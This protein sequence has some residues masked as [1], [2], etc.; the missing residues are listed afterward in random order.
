MSKF[1][2]LLELLLENCQFDS[3]N[4]SLGFVNFTSLRVLALSKNHFNYEIPNWFSNLST[5]LLQLY[6]DNSFL[7][8]NIPPCIFSLEK[9]EYLSLYTNKLTEQIPEPLVQLKHLTYLDLGLNSLNG[10]TPSFIGNLSCIRTLLLDQ[11]QLNGTIPKN[12][13]LLS[14]LETLFVGKNSL[15]GTVD[16]RHFRKLSKLKN[17]YMSETRLFFNVNSNW[18]LPFQLVSASMSSTKIGPNFSFMA[19]ITKIPQFF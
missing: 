7:K 1:P 4:P 16:E 17:L 3:L 15:T 18:V 8:G 11:N 14:K 6:M 5:S 13:G 10:P 12:L 9:L 2:S 19:T